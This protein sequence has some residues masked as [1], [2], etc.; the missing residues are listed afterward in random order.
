[1]LYL[2]DI[3]FFLVPERLFYET[4]RHGHSP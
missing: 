4:D 2:P 3:V 1:V